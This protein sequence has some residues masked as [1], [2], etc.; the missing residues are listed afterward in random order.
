MNAG[1][2]LVVDAWAGMR[3][4]RGRLALAMGSLA[5]GLAL[6]ALLLAVLAAFRVQADRVLAGFGAQALVV[7]SQRPAGTPGGGIGAED[8]ARLRHQF[9]EARLGVLRQERQ[10]LAAER[11]PVNVL[12]GDGSLAAVRGWR[13][14]AGRALDPRDV[15]DGVRHAVVSEALA[16]E[17]GL[18]PGAVLTLAGVPFEIVGLVA[19]EG[20]GAPGWPPAGERFIW[21]PHTVPPLWRRDADPATLGVDLVYLEF[22]RPARLAVAL[23]EG[24]RL[25]RAAAG[26]APAYDWITAERLLA[27]IRRLRLAVGFV[28]GAVAA[29]CLLLGAALL[30]NVL[31][32]GVRARVAEIG[33]RRAFGAGP[34]DVAALFMMEALLT[35]TAAAGL[36]LALAHLVLAAL[37][38]R[39]PLPVSIHASAWW[40]PALAA[41]LLALICAAVPAILAARI[42]PYEAL[43]ND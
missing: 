7:I 28:V 24:P 11:P 6:L 27:G 36:G 37:G 29:L 5:I 10:A 2:R 32:S 12:A 39:L 34:A 42:A 35:T 16:R 26:R 41:L 14:T 8:V 3:S 17:D 38:E 31:V 20:A 9:P 15:Q 19:G 33:L 1:V 13:I 21:I 40:G 25:L 18:T 23:V 22:E 4:R 30:A 43:R